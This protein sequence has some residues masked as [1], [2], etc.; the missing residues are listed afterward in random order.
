[1]QYVPIWHKSVTFAAFFGKTANLAKFLQ[2][3]SMTSGQSGMFIGVILPSKIKI[4]RV[5]VK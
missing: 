5:C 3:K 1:M 4:T 2:T